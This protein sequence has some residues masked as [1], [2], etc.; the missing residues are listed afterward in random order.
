MEPTAIG[1]VIHRIAVIGAG[2]MGHGIAQ[3]FAL[4]GYDVRLHDVSDEKLDHALDRIDANVQM[5]VGLGLASPE[6]TA[7]VRDRIRTSTRLEDLIGDVDLVIE[8]IVENFDVKH[9]TFKALDEGCPAHTIFASNTSSF[10]P[11]QLAVATQRPDRVLVAHYFNPPHLLPLVEVVR[12]PETSD[13][14]VTAVWNLL[15]TIGKQPALVRRE[16]PG[17]IGNRLQFAL[18]REATSLVE[19][20]IATAEDVDIVI[21]SSIGRRW[22]AAGV[23]EVFEVAGWDLIGE[24]MRNLLPHLA[25]STDYPPSLND[26]MTNGEFGLKTGQGYYEWTPETADALRQRIAHIL[27]LLAQQSVE[28]E[29]KG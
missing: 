27:A 12:G 26:R 13:T 10:M 17:F 23:F 29:R 5:L 9:A 2:L 3:E 16:T 14:T 15:L 22:A 21:K 24:I 8:A 19:Q 25:S 11:S 1:S 18:L 6:K 20:G 28:T 7:G 4:A